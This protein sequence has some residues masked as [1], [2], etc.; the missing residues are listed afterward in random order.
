MINDYTK[1][2]SKSQGSFKGEKRTYHEKDNMLPDPSK[3]GT[4][5]I[6]TTVKEKLDYFVVGSAKFI[7]SLMSQEKTNATGVAKAELIVDGGSWGELTSLELLRLK[8]LLESA[9]L[10]NLTQML[11]SIP[12]RSDA[13]VWKKSHNEDYQG[14]D[15]YENELQ[16][17]V[18]ITTVKE[19]YVLKD[20]NLAGNEFPPHYQSPIVTK[21]K[22]VELG[23]YTRQNFSGEWSHR[24]RAMCLRRK[25]VLLT[26]I[27]EALKVAN[28]VEAIQS[29]VT[30]KK[31]FGYLFY[32]DK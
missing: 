19:P 20:P 13:E 24:E 4:T 23:D 29:E 30:A 22:I 21:D 3:Q 7:D 6:A 15:V 10:G 28:E 14:R 31:I 16:S 5:L 26:A 27:T 17:G 11:Q 8:S 12:V 18:A 1:F 2:F 25:E 9:D 32:N